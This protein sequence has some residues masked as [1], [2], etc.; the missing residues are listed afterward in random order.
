[1]QEVNGLAIIHHLTYALRNTSLITHHHY[2]PPP[3]VSIVHYSVPLMP[4]SPS[5]P[6]PR[7]ENSYF[8]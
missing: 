7:N 3:A 4:L 6:A 8:E 1:M 2:H 5:V